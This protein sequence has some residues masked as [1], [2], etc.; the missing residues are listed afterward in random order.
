MAPDK[1]TVMLT[2]AMWC[3]KHWQW[4]RANPTANGIYASIKL[5]EHAVARPEMLKAL[6]YDK[7]KGALADTCR[8]NDVL[9]SF[10]PL[11]CFLGDD[12]VLTLLKESQ[13]LK[14]N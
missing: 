13:H 9:P 2:E 12:F 10:Y 11:C 4:W 6:G 3:P 5:F 14:P 7:E 8:L 1:P